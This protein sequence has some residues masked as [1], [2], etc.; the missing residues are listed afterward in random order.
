MACFQVLPIENQMRHPKEMVGWNGVLST[1]MTMV[2]SPKQVTRVTRVKSI[3]CTGADPTIAAL[4]Q[5]RW[6]CSRL[7]CFPRRKKIFLFKNVPSYFI[8][9]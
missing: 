7:E 5:Q 8:V 4:K 2:S 9:A 6:R 1:S 3:W